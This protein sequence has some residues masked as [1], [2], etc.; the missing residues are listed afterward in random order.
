MMVK[1]DFVPFKAALNQIGTNSSDAL[2]KIRTGVHDISS[3]ASGASAS[4]EEIASSVAILAENS[5]RVSSLTC[6]NDAGLDQ[7]LTA[8][9]DLTDTVGEVAQRT[10]S[11]SE[12][13]NHA[14]NL[15]HDG[16]KLT[17]LAGKGME[18]ILE[19]FEKIST[20]VSD[21]SNQMEEIGG[22][23]GV[24][25]AIAEQTSLLALNAAIEAAR[26]GDAGRGFT[27]VADEVKSLAQESQTSTE[28]ISSIIGNLQKRSAEMTVG[29]SKAADVMQ[30]GNN[31]VNK[32]IIVFHQMNEAI[33]DVNQNIS[34]VAA[35]SEEQAASV[36]EITA[37]MSEVRDMV[38]DTAREATDSAAAAEEIS[39]ALVQL[40]D[41]A[42]QSA[43]FAEKI[44]GL[45][46]QFKIK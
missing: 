24:I 15:A 30:S 46:N 31:A 13:A 35:A 3:G 12:L 4:I 6:R 43:Q 16:V 32:T 44:A 18:E 11:V 38:Q 41:T 19:S 28:H 33:A 27:V 23:V 36:E 29:I 26:A 40:K 1:G 17:E 42:L 39:A 34:E 45:V 20:D 21:I 22:I 10:A 2:L 5:S 25:S 37:S 8:M 7:A 14:S 9:N